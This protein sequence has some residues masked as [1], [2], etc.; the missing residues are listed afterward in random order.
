[1]RDEPAAVLA[2]EPL[3]RAGFAPFGDAI[4]LSLAEGDGRAANQGTARRHDHAA[5]VVNARPGTATPHLALFR[6]V[7]RALPVTVP[8]LERHP[9]S[10]QLFVPLGDAEVIVVVA[11]TAEG[12]GPALHGARAFHVRPGQGVSYHPGTW[13]AP[14]IALDADAD[15]LMFAHEAQTHDDCE[16]RPLDAPLLVTGAR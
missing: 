2:L 3:T 6:S 1:V 8:L 12:G 13:H 16:E 14:I 5:R 9:A 15:L 7:G 11:P 10:T 4:G